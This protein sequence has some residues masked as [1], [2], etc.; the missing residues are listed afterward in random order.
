M[1]LLFVIAQLCELHDI[2]DVA[3]VY[4]CR[5]WMH[6]IVMS[7]VLWQRWLGIQL[8]K[9]PIQAS[10]KFLLWVLY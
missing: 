4:L 1:V 10:P 8:V 6:R 3:W 2:K 5:L 9:Q 7:S